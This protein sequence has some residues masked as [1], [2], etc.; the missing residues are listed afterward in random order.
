MVLP[1][2]DPVCIL[3]HVGV[4]KQTVAARYRQR[5][6]FVSVSNYIN[7]SDTLCVLYRRC[8]TGYNYCYYP[9]AVYRQ[10]ADVQPGPHRLLR[11]QDF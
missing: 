10:H 8:G 11:R 1:V 3:Q 7:N 9:V 5:N 6:Y 4:F 2:P